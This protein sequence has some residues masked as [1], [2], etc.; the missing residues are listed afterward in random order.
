MAGSPQEARLVLDLNDA[1]VGAPSRV[2]KNLF[3]VKTLFAPCDKTGFLP[4]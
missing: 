3:V 1:A 2:R 4:F